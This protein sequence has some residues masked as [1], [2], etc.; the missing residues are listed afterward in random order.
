VRKMISCMTGLWKMCRYIDRNYEQARK[1]Y[2]RRYKEL[3]SMSFWK[4]YLEL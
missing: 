4:K 2:T 1:T 3:T